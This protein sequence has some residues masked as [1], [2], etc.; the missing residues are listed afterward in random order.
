MNYFVKKM[1][2]KNIKSFFGVCLILPLLVISC[3]GEKKF[4][5]DVSDID[6][7]I[8]ILRFEQD[9]AKIDTFNF[10]EQFAEL[11][12]KYPGFTEVYFQ[13]IIADRPVK[14]EEIPVYALEIIKGGYLNDLL[15][16]IDIAFPDLT[17]L[18]KDINSMMQFYRYYFADSSTKTLVTFCSEFGVGACTIGE[19]TLG[20]GLDM[21]LGSEFPDYDPNVFPTFIR[22]SHVSRIYSGTFDKIN[23]SKYYS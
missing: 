11:I 3:T 1:F 2:R 20:L 15:D 13:Q 6:P 21:Y 8:Q 22:K 4:I 9:L 5:P 16:S 14:K 10:E 12:Q 7:G 17:V 18:M 19:D 23:D